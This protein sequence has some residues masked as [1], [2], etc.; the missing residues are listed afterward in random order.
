MSA[1]LPV[2][3]NASQGEAGDTSRSTAS[4]T[5]TGA[6]PTRRRLLALMVSLATASHQLIDA[7]PTTTASS[8]WTPTPDPILALFAEFQ[9]LPTSHEAALAEADWLEAGLV[10]DIGY[11]RVRLTELR[12]FIEALVKPRR[13]SRA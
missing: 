13:A 12:N 6:A 1:G 3:P 7:A 8:N 2:D 9:T 11:P 4:E 10:A 5:A